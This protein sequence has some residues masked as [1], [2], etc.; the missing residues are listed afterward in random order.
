[1][2]Y[3]TDSSVILPHFLDYLIPP[4]SRASFH[5]G[6]TEAKKRPHSLSAILQ[7]K[8]SKLHGKNIIAFASAIFQRLPSVYFIHLTMYIG[9]YMTC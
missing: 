8:E 4:N 6:S 5:T 7:H 9:L 2:N 3:S 1:M